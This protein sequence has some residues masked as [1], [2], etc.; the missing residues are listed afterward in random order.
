MPQNGSASLLRCV[1][2]AL[3]VQI[4]WALLASVWNVAGVMLIANGQRAPGPTA[5]ITGAVVLAGFAL[6][7]PLAVR[8]W[9][10]LYLILSV[11]TGLICVMAVVNAFVQDP[12]LWP[13]EFWRYAGA[14]LNGAGGIAAVV[15]VFGYVSWKRQAGNQ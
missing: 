3:P 14:V 12:A 13:S 9:P 5:T 4:I 7:F 8:R 2:W 6:L 15:A 10:V 1:S 11:L